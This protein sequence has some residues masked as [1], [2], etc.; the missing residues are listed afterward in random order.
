MRRM[1]G[2]SLEKER[3]VEATARMPDM[4]TGTKRIAGGRPV[5]CG[6]EGCGEDGGGAGTEGGMGGG[7]GIDLRKRKE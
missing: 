3:E 2:P 7:G 6:G 5:G 1:W 4:A